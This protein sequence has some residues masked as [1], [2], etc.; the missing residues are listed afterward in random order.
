MW[1]LRVA[2]TA[3]DFCS[4]QPFFEN[5]FNGTLLELHCI[6][7]CLCSTLLFVLHDD[8]P[9][10]DDCEKYPFSH[11]L[12]FRGKTTPF[13]LS[14]GVLICRLDGL[15]GLVL[16]QA[17]CG[18]GYIERGRKKDE[19]FLCRVLHSSQF[20]IHCVC[21]RAP[22][23]SRSLLFLYHRDNLSC[24]SGPFVTARLVFSGVVSS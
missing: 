11:C 1:I 5:Q 12:L 20:S 14:R 7:R 13:V 2:S 19:P 21:L 18:A 15:S 3:T 23:T 17:T 22:N 4:T 6:N 8:T 24:R 16:F 10:T 9:L